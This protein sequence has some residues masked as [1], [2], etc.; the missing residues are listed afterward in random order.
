MSKR[1]S[2]GG[3][4]KDPNAQKCAKHDPG[5]EVRWTSGGQCPLCE[6][7]ESGQRMTKALRAADE[8]LSALALLPKKMCPANRGLHQ[9]VQV[10]L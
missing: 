8:Y 1:K 6:T 2:E 3:E 7:Q 4:R 10:F 9:S 5:V